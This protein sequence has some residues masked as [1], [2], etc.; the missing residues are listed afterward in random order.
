LW[1]FD[2]CNIV[3]SVKIIVQIS[4]KHCSLSSSF[5]LVRNEK[6]SA[7]KLLNEPETYKYSYLYCNNPYTFQSICENRAKPKPSYTLPT[8]FSSDLHHLTAILQ[9]L[10]AMYEHRH[11]I[12]LLVVAETAHKAIDIPATLSRRATTHA[13]CQWSA[14]APDNAADGDHAIPPVSLLQRT[15]DS[16]ISQSR[17]METRK[18]QTAANLGAKECVFKHWIADHSVAKRDELYVVDH[19]DV[20]R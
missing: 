6:E 17:G 18:Q 7:T 11:A 10:A 12:L 4:M 5:G 8:V 15:H 19:Y 2:G 1:I 9:H 13:E 3:S 20:A 16:L 14:C